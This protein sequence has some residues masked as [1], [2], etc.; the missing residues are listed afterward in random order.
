MKEACDACVSAL[1]PVCGESSAKVAD[2]VAIKLALCF[3]KQCALLVFA[4]ALPWIEV[5]ASCRKLPEISQCM[6]C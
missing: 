6:K 3:E 2:S 4:Y 1:P 5:S